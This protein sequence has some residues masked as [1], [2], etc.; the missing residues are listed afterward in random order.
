[1][2]KAGPN[3]TV[4]VKKILTSF[5]IVIGTSELFWNEGLKS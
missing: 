3:P 1:V 2:Y 5:S 4:D